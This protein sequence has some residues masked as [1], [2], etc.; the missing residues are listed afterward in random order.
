MLSKN[1]KAN[2]SELHIFQDKS[3]DFCAVISLKHYGRGPAIGGCRMLPYPTLDAA[4]TDANRLAHAM[5]YKAAI[6]QLP[7]DGGKAVIMRST[8]QVDRTA[9]LKRFAECVNSLNG[10]YITTID[11]GTSQA[12]MSIL[13]K[14][15]PYVVG[16]L[17]EDHSDNNPSVSTAWGIFKGIQAAANLL[18]G[19]DNVAGLH[20][21]IQGV[22]SVGY[23]LAKYLFFAGARLTVCDTDPTRAQRCSEEFN[24]TI[25]E[26]FAIYAVPCDIFSPC[27]LGQTINALTL[28]QFK[29]KII[30]GAAN[31][32]LSS[33]ELAKQ[34]A[35]R[36]ILY[37]PD[38][39]TN[40]GGLIHLSLQK[41]NKSKEMI[42]EYVERI[43]ERILN[44]ATTA[45]KQKKTLYE[46]TEMT[47]ERFL[48]GNAMF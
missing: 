33:P 47:V 45:A 29:T 10:R 12:D 37:V 30:A 13:K 20:V 16:Y 32:Q 42:T 31:D 26:P 15:T 2:R 44:L 5:S 27:A 3:L 40:A 35:Q 9:I 4:I 1:D 38:Y 17:E 43:S 23:F 8:Q 11:S 18:E 6:S 36:N 39:L 28:T 19:R 22:G 46:M 14:Y 34:L 25:V 48:C 24:A 7:H 21:A 41:E